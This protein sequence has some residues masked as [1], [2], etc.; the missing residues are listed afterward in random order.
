MLMDTS[1]SQLGPEALS[2]QRSAAREV[3]GRA[4]SRVKNTKLLDPVRAPPFSSTVVGLTLAK[5]ASTD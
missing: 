4:A 2:C 1:T 3:P 5:S